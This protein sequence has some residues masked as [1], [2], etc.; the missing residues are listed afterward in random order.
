RGAHRLGRE[1]AQRRLLGGRGGR[2]DARVVRRP[3]PFAQAL[4][5]D[6]GILAGDG[7]DLPGEQVQDDAVL[8][9]GPGAAVAAQ[10][11]GAGA[12]LAAEAQAAVAQT[13]D[14]PLEADGDLAHLAP[15]RARDP[16]DERA[17]HQRLA[18][19]G[20]GRPAVAVRVQV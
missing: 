14:E 13:G 20:A 4:V 9:G 3:E 2:V 8:V 5:V 17:R 16:V 6:A 12:L 11:A 10:E 15:E 1:L 7:G 19:R 18:D